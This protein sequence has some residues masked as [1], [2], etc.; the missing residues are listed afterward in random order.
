MDQEKKI[1]MPR[2]LWDRLS[3]MMEREGITSFS[4]AVR[5]CVRKDVERSEEVAARKGE[6]Q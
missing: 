6:S 2:I 1:K 5:H 3:A 4:E